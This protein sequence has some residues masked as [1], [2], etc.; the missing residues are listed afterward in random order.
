MHL[1]GTDD[2]EEDEDAGRGRQPLAPGLAAADAPPAG[3]QGP[4]PFPRLPPPPPRDQLFVL[5]SS[6]PVSAVLGGEEDVAVLRALKAGDLLR[7][8]WLQHD[9]EGAEGAGTAGEGAGEGAPPIVGLAL[10]CGNSAAPAPDEGSPPR[11][12]AELRMPCPRA[13]EALVSLC[14]PAAAL[15]GAVGGLVTV[16][17]S[18]GPS[19]SSP[20]CPSR[21]R[22]TFSV[23]L[24]LCL[25]PAALADAA[26]HAGQGY[27]DT[28][29]G[30]Q[31]LPLLRWLRGGRLRRRRRRR[32]RWRR[33]RRRRLLLPLLLLLLLLVLLP[34]STPPRSSPRSAL[35]GTPRASEDGTA[36]ASGG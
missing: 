31:L 35:R 19:P 14:R 13:A 2:G 23:S 36:A 10:A 20:P 6:I 33:L 28:Q 25:T 29:L 18:G 34:P 26:A 8:V 22:A 1:V 16:G 17:V 7:P 5:A 9:E 15:G 11:V 3:K 24:S 21:P 4:R 32:R 12:V 30:R 27:D